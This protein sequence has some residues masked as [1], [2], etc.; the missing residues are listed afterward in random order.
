MDDDIVRLLA[1][2]L[3]PLLKHYGGDEEDAAQEARIALWETY[4]PNDPVAY[5]I[6][7]ARWRA[8]SNVHARYKRRKR[9]R[10]V[11]PERFDY[12]RR[13]N[14]DDKLDA[15]Y[16][17]DKIEDNRDLVE[18]HVM[19]GESYDEIAASTGF[20]P[21]GVKQRVL[22][23]LMKLRGGK[24]APSKGGKRGAPSRRYIFDLSRLDGKVREVCELLNQGMTRKE[25][26]AAFGVT[27]QSVDWRIRVAKAKI[28]G[29][30]DQLAAEMRE[31]GRMRYLRKKLGAE[32]KTKGVRADS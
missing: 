3:T 4:D 23:A 15:L 18:R 16:Y 11:F 13:E 9:V 6:H 8:H 5:R 7:K 21:D 30:Y 28:S 22:Y 26:A 24:K 27:P 10:M 19:R 31:R 25:V 12:G 20:T 17:L 29:R 14:V 32:R 2:R 1:F